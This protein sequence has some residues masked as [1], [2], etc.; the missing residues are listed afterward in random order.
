VTTDHLVAADGWAS[1]VRQRLGIG[2]TGPGLLYSTITAIVEA[3]LNPALR[4]RRATIAYLQR[5][6]PFTVL[7]SHDDHGRR[8]VFGTGYDPRR[9]SIDGFS[10]ERIAAM[11]RAASGLPDV[12]VTLRPQIPGTD[13]KVLG[14]PIAAQIADRYRDGRVFLVGDAAHP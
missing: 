12:A 10:D 7:M 11:V 13:L 5:P 4:G 1:P 14:F 3:D 8:W 9:E 6:A 2:L